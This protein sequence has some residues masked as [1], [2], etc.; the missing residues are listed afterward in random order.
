MKTFIFMDLYKSV[1][2]RVQL[3]VFKIK[4]C[5]FDRCGCLMSPLGL[6]MENMKGFC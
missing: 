4:E 5:K 1:L 2:L 6:I 3:K